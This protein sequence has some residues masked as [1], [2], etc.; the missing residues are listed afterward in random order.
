MTIALLGR[1]L[2]M[3][4][5]F[6]EDG[7]LVP[8]TV[9]EVGP[10]PIVQIKSPESDRYTA[11]QIGYGARRET[12]LRRAEQA[13]EERARAREEG[14]RPRIR[15]PKQ[16]LVTQAALGHAKRAGLMPPRVLREVRVD[17]AS[18]YEVGQ[19]LRVDLF[20]VGERV[21]VTGT[22][23]GRG[24]AGTIKRHHTSRGPETH[25]SRYH[26]RPGSMGASADPSRV[27]KG[28]PGAGRM[29]TARTTVKNLQVVQCDPEN[30]LLVLRGAVP[31]HNGSLVM[32]SKAPNGK[33][34]KA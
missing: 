31:G 29:G 4:R 23:K 12:A 16:V 24:F 33:S 13:R 28:K 15:A 11:I 19:E 34:R 26:R 17:D 32:V 14:R 20:E 10:C 9:L 2:G 5:V 27:R 7:T 22:S 30:N 18:G 8:V 25:G 21:H 1:K 6:I 3:T